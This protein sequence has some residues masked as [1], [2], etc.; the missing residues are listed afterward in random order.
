MNKIVLAVISFCKNSCF[1]KCTFVPQK[2]YEI[3][4]REIYMV[5]SQNNKYLQIVN[6]V[7][8]LSI[9]AAKFKKLSIRQ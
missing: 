2:F 6:L 5:P 1:T 4:G 9:S 8:K 3:G 7:R